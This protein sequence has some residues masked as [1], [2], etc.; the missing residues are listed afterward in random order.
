MHSAKGAQWLA[1][2]K[3][4]ECVHATTRNSQ[5]L[6]EMGGR[7]GTHKT[8]LNKGVGYDC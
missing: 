2:G 6:S 5:V 7:V 8:K 1:R 3:G 4:A